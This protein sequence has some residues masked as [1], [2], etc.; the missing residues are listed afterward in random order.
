MGEWKRE[1]IRQLIK[2]LLALA[3]GVFL[4][5]KCGEAAIFYWLNDVSK[6]TTQGL[7]GLY[8]RLFCFFLGVLLIIWA[9][10][11]LEKIARIR[12]KNSSKTVE[13]IAWKHFKI[14]EKIEEFVV[15][16]TPKVVGL[17]KL[18]RSNAALIKTNQPTA[19]LNEEDVEKIKNISL[20]FLPKIK[21]DASK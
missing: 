12:L 6:T 3:I 18:T 21:N 1:E 11:V 7:L 14:A 15:L 20:N 4:V 13:A 2:G 9:V 5:F 8:L 16:Q 10:F 17:T 19:F